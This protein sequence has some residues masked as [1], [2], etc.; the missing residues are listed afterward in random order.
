MSTTKI[1]MRGPE[2]EEAAAPAYVRQYGDSHGASLTR[3]AQLSNPEFDILLGGFA[4]YSEKEHGFNRPHLIEFVV[5][6]THSL[7]TYSPGDAQDLVDAIIELAMM[8]RVE[9]RRGRDVA[10]DVALDVAPNA[11]IE[12][13]ALEARLRRL[14]QEKTVA[15]VAGVDDLLAESDRVLIESRIITDVRPVYEDEDG[16]PVVKDSMVLHTLRIQ[17]WQDGRE[18]SFSV[19]LRP[20]DLEDLARAVRR[21]EDKEAGLAGLRVRSRSGE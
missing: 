4:S 14:L 18:R 11:G 9:A 12:T 1:E 21:A 3:M 13:S 17:Y 7:T 5:T 20:S 6:A 8:H 16:K 19:T 10:H 15:G 2:M